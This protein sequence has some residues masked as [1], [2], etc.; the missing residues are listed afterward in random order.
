MPQFW[1]RIKSLFAHTPEP[2]PEPWD[3]ERSARI[4]EFTIIYDTIDEL[5]RLFLTGSVEVYDE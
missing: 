2:Q 5:R 4:D 3:A 1:S